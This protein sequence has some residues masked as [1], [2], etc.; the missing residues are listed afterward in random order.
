MLYFKD[1]ATYGLAMAALLFVLRHWKRGYRWV[2]MIVGALLLTPLT[3]FLIEALLRS[4]DGGGRLFRQW[5]FPP[6]N[7]GPN[8]VFWGVLWV[9]LLWFWVPRQIP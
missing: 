4:P 2:A 3:L 8:I 6:P 7:L 5:P 9:A 1:F